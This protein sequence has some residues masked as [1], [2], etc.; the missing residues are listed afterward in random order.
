MGV[1][2]SI[3]H[4]QALVS[5]GLAELE[6]LFLRGARLTGAMP[7]LSPLTKLVFVNLSENPFA[8][9]TVPPWATSLPAVQSLGLSKTNRQGALPDLS[10]TK[11]RLVYLGLS[12]NAF[13]A[14]AVPDWIGT[15]ALLEGLDGVE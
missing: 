4:G 7:D 10:A 11:D 5:S 13:D 14:G 3:Y 15:M 6:I 9:G 12:Q 2:R 1:Y 8:A